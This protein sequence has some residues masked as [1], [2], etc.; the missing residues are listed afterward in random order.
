MRV[1]IFVEQPAT[2]GGG[3]QQTLSTVVALAEG[4]KGHEVMVLAPRGDIAQA[5]A[6]HGIA[7]HLYPDGPVARLLEVLPALL[8]QAERVLAGLRR[9]GLRGL[10]RGL[11]R[12]LAALGVDLA[13][14]NLASTT[15][16]RLAEHPFVVTVW[17]LCHR[18]HPEFPEVA[19][20]RE[21]E[22]REQVLNAILPKAIAVIANAPGGAA[23]IAATYA[24]DPGRIR[25][26]PF[27]PALATR[28]HAAGQG[29]VTAAQVRARYGLPDAFAFYPA[30]PWPHKNHVYL[31]EAVALL[32][33]RHGVRLDIVLSGGAAAGFAHVEDRARALGIADRVHI[34]GFVADEAMPA[35]YE[36]A[37]MLVMPTY[38]GPTNLPPLEAALLGCPVI[39]ADT[40]SFRAQ[41][42]PAALYCDL[43]DP[44]SLAEH[45][46]RIVTD[47][48]CATQLRQAGRELAAGLDG[49][50]YAREFQQVF[51]DF[52]WKR[53]LWPA[54]A[55]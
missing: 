10:G 41:M 49:D 17:D 8:P 23:Q 35:L 3:F 36:C 50:A 44:A 4:L 2:A 32:E 29:S 47:P 13:V 6:R 5:F 38:F 18:D 43:A 39:Y 30:N 21:F 7:T 26:V 27:L 48:A 46:H 25:V 15:A 37:T 45:M 33:R 12:R 19:G 31:L 9:L 51:D 52:A 20:S 55:S 34:L 11:D 40:A 14:F 54:R 1:A 28:R 24:V 53:R 42:G 22:R 16:L